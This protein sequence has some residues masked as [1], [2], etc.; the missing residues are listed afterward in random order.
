V[1]AI[2]AKNGGIADCAWKLILAAA[3]RWRPDVKDDTAVDALNILKLAEVFGVDGVSSRPEIRLRT[4]L[5]LADAA[6]DVVS[7]C[8]ETNSLKSGAETSKRWAL[9]A[10]KTCPT[11]ARNFL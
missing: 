11:R 6:I 9:L 2:N 3:L 5:M 7:E 8:F 10:K 4:H 1:N